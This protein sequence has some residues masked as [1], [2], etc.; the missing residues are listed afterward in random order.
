MRF[1]AYF[2]PIIKVLLYVMAAISFVG[3]IIGILVLAGVPIELS[4]GQATL[5]LS[6]CPLCT[7]VA[8]L[9]ATLHYKVEKNFLR[10]YIGFI[11]IFGSRIRI[12]KILNI[13]I[14]DERMYISYL[15]KDGVDP[16]ISAIVI[17]PR[18]YNEMKDALM[19]KNPN[20]IFHETKNESTD[21]QQ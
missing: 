8:L 10:L 3:A 14:S 18:R 9:F 6:V 15:Y 4:S 5:L 20:I 17:N 13:V 19:S 2:T 21:S 7:I 11:N 16:I 12:D 1:Q